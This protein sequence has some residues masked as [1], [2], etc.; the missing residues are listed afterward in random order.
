MDKDEVYSLIDSHYRRNFNKLVVK[1]HG[2]AAGFHNS[3]DAVQEAYTRALTYWHTFNPEMQKFSTWFNRI[4][5]NTIKDQKHAD[6]IHGMSEEIEDEDLITFSPNPFFLR[7][8]EEIRHDILDLPPDRAEV[9]DMHLFQQMTLVDISKV[10][11]FTLAAI[12]KM[13][14]RF[15][16]ELRVKYEAEKG[17]CG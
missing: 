16:E 3:E 2:K 7:W 14:S 4:L 13:V 11:D 10:T 17:M 6:R 12:K 8:L 9:M 1:C 15:K 5:Q